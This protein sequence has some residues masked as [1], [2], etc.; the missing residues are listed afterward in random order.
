MPSFARATTRKPEPGRSTAW[1][2][3]DCTVNAVSPTIAASRESRLD[4][5]LV[6]EHV[7]SCRT[8]RDVTAVVEVLHEIAAERHVD[9]LHAAADA[10]QRCARRDRGPHEC[11][12]GSVGVAEDL[13]SPGVVG[14]AAIE[15]RIHILTTR[16]K[17]GIRGGEFGLEVGVVRDDAPHREPRADGRR[18]D[19]FAQCAQLGAVGRVG[20]LAVADVDEEEAGVLALLVHATIVAERRCWGRGRRETRCGLGDV[21]R[22]VGESG[23]RGAADRARRGGVTAV[24][25]NR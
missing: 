20:A 4:R 14:C 13:F 18:R 15:R 2:C 12:L 25:E 8:G 6:P 19:A 24:S 1:W 17:H 7:G 23:I 21:P 3:D 16:K 22:R 11:R 10:D 5:D 9:H